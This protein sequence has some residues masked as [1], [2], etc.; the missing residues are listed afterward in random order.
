MDIIRL[1]AAASILLGA[2]SAH[3]AADIEVEFTPPA[4]VEVYETGRYTVRIANTGDAQ[5]KNV[6]A[7]I[8]LPETGTSPQVYLMGTL[9]A[10]HRQCQAISDTILECNFGRVKAGRAKTRWFELALPAVR[11]PIDF[12]VEAR[13]TSNESSTANNALSQT[14]SPA[15]IATPVGAPRVAVNRHCTGQGLTAFF[16]CT[17]FPSSISSHQIT[18]EAD[19][20]ITFANGA[21]GYTGAWQQPWPEALYFTYSN[22]GQI[23]A[24]FSGV[25]VGGDCFEGLTVFPGSAYVAPYE[26]CLQ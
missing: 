19:G 21:P 25:G 10:L 16:E 12:V 14:V 26:V 9:G 7:Y 24:A 1:L 6:K 2:V 8:Q 20:S 23:A 18:L 5:A 22:N 13:T 17:L 15:A 11:G 4:G 3:A